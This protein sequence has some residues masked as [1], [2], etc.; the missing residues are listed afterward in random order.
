MKS[1]YHESHEIKMDDMMTA[2]QPMMNNSA[3]AE[4]TSHISSF[5]DNVP[6]EKNLLF[7]GKS[8]T[9][10]DALRR[11]DSDLLTTF[12][13]QSNIL[14][15]YN[16]P[17]GSVG[18][19]TKY[20]R[21]HFLAPGNYF[22]IGLGVHLQRVV[23]EIHTTADGT[24]LQHID[25]CYLALPENDVA[26][27]QVG[28]KQV[29]L[30]SGRYLLR[31][32]CTLF[33]IVNVQRL[34]RKETVT[35]ISESAGPD[36]HDMENKVT[37]TSGHHQNCGA[38]TFMRPEPGFCGVVQDSLGELR[39]FTG[40]TM[41]RGGEVFKKFIDLQNYARTTRAFKLESKDRHEV[42]IRVQ[43]RWHVIDAKTW[44]LKQ[45]ASE[46]IFDAIEE[47][48]QAVMRDAIASNTY[49]DC[50]TQAGEGYEGIEQVVRTPLAAAAEA[51]GAELL[52][53]EIRELRFPLLEPRNQARA[54]QE[55]K[56]SEELQEIK[57]RRDIERQEHEKHQEN[58][59]QENLRAQQQL[60]HDIMMEA[61]REKQNIAK[62]NSAANV[63]KAESEQEI[64][65]MKNKLEAENA[66]NLIR[67]QAQEDNIKAEQA[68]KLIEEQAEQDRLL[69]KA[70]AAAEC[71]LEQSKSLAQAT[72]ANAEAEAA[73]RLKL[74]EADA[75][76]AELMG[77]AYGKNGEVIKLKMAE[78]QAEVM[79][80]RAQALSVAMSNNKGCMMPQ[81]LQRELAILDAG[82]SPIAPYVLG[83]GGMSSPIPG[84]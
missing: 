10:I 17:A 60:E 42:K 65:L 14:S 29:V 83:L 30:G 6:E 13:G 24:S 63:A 31:S 72:I 54:M 9:F 19:C 64:L 71:Q 51:L 49:E 62:V 34:S 43:I 57:R 12:E 21:T 56:L 39:T 48:C 41:A 2:R 16:I 32:P 46:D 55:S 80:A 82:H 77:A 44:V 28:N 52:G 59:R 37:L 3:G 84:K 70:R 4:T 68:R 81:D 45:G 69:I 26:V 22:R 61:L 35:V 53:M 18:L 1:N 79:K 5:V 7:V 74:A 15:R 73:A 58:Q 25:I 11:M 47:I 8:E 66:A 38:V 40:F 67:L 20:G 50:M 78:M 76:A 27:V 23:E 75:K 36:G 33:G